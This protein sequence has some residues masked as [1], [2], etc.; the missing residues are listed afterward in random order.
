MERQAQ[1]RRGADLGHV[2]AEARRAKGFTQAEMAHEVGLT[3]VYLSALESGRSTP[4]LEHYLRALRRI[5]AEVTVTYTV[6]ESKENG[7]G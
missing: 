4:L 6:P 5:G 1:I 7:D 3:R 2:L